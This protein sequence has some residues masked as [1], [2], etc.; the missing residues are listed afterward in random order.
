MLDFIKKT[1]HV[2]KLPV[3]STKPIPVE[4]SKDKIPKIPFSLCIY[5][6]NCTSKVSYVGYTW[7]DLCLRTRKRV[8]KWLG[9]GVMKSSN[10]PTIPHLVD[11]E[12]HIE[13]G[14][15]FSV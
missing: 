9:K 15:A 13:R 3:A 2:A 4:R 6:F 12:H 14:K 8:P 1:F 7:S 11:G 5:Q 10:S